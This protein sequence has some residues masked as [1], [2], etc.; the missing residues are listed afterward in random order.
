MS[1]DTPQFKERQIVYDKFN[2]YY[3]FVGYDLQKHD[4][5]IVESVVTKERF[6]APLVELFPTDREHKG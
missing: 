3:W 5:G 4:M 6:L 2:N 1:L